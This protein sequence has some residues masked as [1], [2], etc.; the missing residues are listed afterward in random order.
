MEI[1][2]HEKRQGKNKQASQLLSNAIDQTAA[3]MP[4][5]AMESFMER[6]EKMER[7]LSERARKRMHYNTYRDSRTRKKDDELSED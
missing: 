4:M 6:S 1:K 5:A 7:G 3:Y 2:P